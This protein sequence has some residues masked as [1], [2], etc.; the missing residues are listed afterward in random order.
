M[1]MIHFYAEVNLLIRALPPKTTSLTWP[2]FS[3]T[4]IVLYTIVSLKVMPLI[5]VLFSLERRGH[6]G[7]DRMVVGFTTTCVNCVY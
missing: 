2:D 7:R 4:E 5:R 1:Y 6:H 3:S